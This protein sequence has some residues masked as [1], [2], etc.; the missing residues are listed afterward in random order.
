[1]S[2][3]SLKTEELVKALKNYKFNFAV[4][5]FNMCVV[6]LIVYGVAELLAGSNSLN[7][8]LADGMVI[9]AALPMTVNMVIVLTKSSGG[10]EAAAVFNAALGNLLGVFLTPAWI[11]ILLGESADIDFGAVVLKLFYRVLIPLAVGQILQFYFPSVKDYVKA[12]K[13]N[14]K[15]SQEFALVFIVYMTFCKTFEDGVEAWW[16][17]I[18]AVMAVQCALLVVLKGVSWGYMA[19][20]FR[21]QPKL[22]IMGFYGGVHKTVA[23]GIPLLNAIYDGDNRLG[24]YTLPLLI[25]HPAQ[26]VIGTYLSPRLAKWVEETEKR[27]GIV[28]TDDDA[29]KPA[30]GAV[31]A[32]DIE[33]ANGEALGVEDTGTTERLVIEG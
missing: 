10:D 27:L 30:D 29:P 2:G 33:L 14:F 20:L 25:W 15:K 26:L 11:L 28:P 6:T 1:M 16:G 9:C 23:M 7:R 19:L 17:D 21:D 24:M 4:Q 12:H 31:D 18:L 22:R 32:N 5:F 3:L 8:D 13:K